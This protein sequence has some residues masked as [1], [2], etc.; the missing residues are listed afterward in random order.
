M[1]KPPIFFLFLKSRRKTMPASGRGG[2]RF[3]QKNLPFCLKE[4]YKYA[5][6]SDVT[7]NGVK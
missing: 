7:L 5:N 6:F 2:R 4:W 1:K 3:Y